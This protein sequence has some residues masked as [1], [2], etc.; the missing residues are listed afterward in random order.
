[1]GS[2]EP[3]GPVETRSLKHSVIELRWDL[4]RG[5]LG[6]SDG[7]AGL[8]PNVPSALAVLRHAPLYTQHR[9]EIEEAFHVLENHVMKNA[10]VY[11]A[12]VV[13]TPF[14]FDMVRRG[15]PLAGR[16]TDLIAKYAGRASSLETRLR[17]SLIAIITDHSTEIAGWV[18]RYDR[19]AAALA[20]HVP[21]LRRE[22]VPAVASSTT[23][24]APCTLLA[25]V[26][27]GAPLDR[28]TAIAFRIL[29]RADLP[30]VARMSAAAYLGAF[31]EDS[32]DLRTRIDEAL[33]PSAAG[34]LERYV[35]E[36]WR[37]TVVRPIVAPRLHAAQIVFVGEKL[38]L[39]RAG[40]RSVTLPWSSAPAKRGDTIQ[41]GLSVHGQPKLAL[42]TE[43]DGRVTVIDF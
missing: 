40:E 14:L 21:E 16:I 33:P 42:L 26:E 25:L 13:A 19:A 31:G 20:I 37:P 15:S 35:G 5:A 4:I 9:A 12:A 1:M 34:A 6:A 7:S 18:G 3:T 43:P 23:K 32:P 8:H 30:T 38:V 22:F 39:V 24:I 2:L 28:A 29:D 11:P 41:V 17:R 10:T 27:I 36:L